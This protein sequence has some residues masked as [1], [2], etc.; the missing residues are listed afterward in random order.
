MKIVDVEKKILRIKG[1]HTMTPEATA[2]TAL[3]QYASPKRRNQEALRTILL[4]AASLVTSGYDRRAIDEIR[5]VLD[6]G[7]TGHPGLGNVAEYKG[8][9]DWS[10]EGT[11]AIEMWAKTMAS[12]QSYNKERGD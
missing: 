7:M 2:G 5:R 9:P 8:Y 11:Q 6:G 3:R 10:E 4:K 1:S 12:T